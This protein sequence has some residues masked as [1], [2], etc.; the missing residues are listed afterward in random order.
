MVVIRGQFTVAVFLDGG[1]DCA[2]NNTK[3]CILGGRG[4]GDKACFSEYIKK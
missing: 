4:N 3:D 1:G 2:K